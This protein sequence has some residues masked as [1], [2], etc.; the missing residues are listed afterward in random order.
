MSRRSNTDIN[1]LTGR[2][3][4]VESVASANP[5]P[6]GHYVVN[7]RDISDRKQREQELERYESIVENTEDGIYMFDEHG[8]F[9]FV[10]QRVIDISGISRDAWVGEHVSIQTDLWDTLRL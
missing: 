5:T 2:T 10:N 1:R 8:R 3:F 9:E 7:T 4:W 6:D